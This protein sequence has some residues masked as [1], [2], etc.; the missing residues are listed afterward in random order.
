ME[1]RDIDLYIA[2]KY[3]T[4]INRTWSQGNCEAMLQK[5][6]GFELPDMEEAVKQFSRAHFLK[7]RTIVHAM[8][9][10]HLSQTF[11]ANLLGISQATVSQHLKKT[12]TTEWRHGDFYDYVKGLKLDAWGTE[13]QREFLKSKGVSVRLYSIDSDFTY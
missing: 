9:E 6:L 7:T 8:N 2:C 4:R 1:T 13:K 12:L 5:Y 3:Q 10:M 11:I